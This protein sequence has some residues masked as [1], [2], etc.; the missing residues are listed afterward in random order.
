MGN[1]GRC[2]LPTPKVKYLMQPTNSSQ[3][4]HCQLHRMVRRPDRSN[5]TA[6]PRSCTYSSVSRMKQRGSVLEHGE[7]CDDCIAQTKR[8]GLWVQHHSGNRMRGLVGSWRQCEM[9]ASG[10]APGTSQSWMVMVVVVFGYPMLAAS[11]LVIH[12]SSRPVL[13]SRP[14]ALLFLFVSVDNVVE[15]TVTRAVT[16]ARCKLPRLPASR[17][18][19]SCPTHRAATHQLGTRDPGQPVCICSSNQHARVEAGGRLQ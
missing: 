5:V 4:M 18:V 11:W 13:C 14:F 3:S 10:R 17:T 15:A 9:N 19:A 6:S 2:V 16:V 8:P 1:K 12:G 7:V